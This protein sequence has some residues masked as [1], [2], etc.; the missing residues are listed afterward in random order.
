M[1]IAMAAA[2][3]T[4]ALVIGADA[5]TAR[6]RDDAI[7]RAVSD[8]AATG[9][10]EAS[11]DKLWTDAKGGV[12]TAV[13]DAQ[14]AIAAG[15]RWLAL[16]RLAQAR[17]SF[18]ATRFTLT[19]PAER[20]D[21]AAF[22]R[23]WS[24]LGTTL[25]AAAPSPAPLDAVR[26]AI[27]RALAEV[28]TPQVQINYDAALEYGRNTQPEYGLYFVGVAD[29]QRQFTILARGLTSTR[30]EAGTAPALRS[31]A[32]EIAAVQRDLLSLY[33]PPASV[34]RH[35]EFIVA[36]SALKEARQYD[37]LR[38]RHAALL[39]LLQGLQRTAMLRRGAPSETDSIAKQI[40]SFRARLEDP[41]VDHSIGL[42]FVE[43]AEAGL[44]AGTPA[45]AIAAAAVAF[46][47]LPRYFE[48]VGSASAMPAAG[49]AAAPVATVTL[50]RWP[51]T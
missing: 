39:K 47:V 27:V 13:K 41:R 48:S 21:L 16:E 42:L 35:S 25:G 50:V 29:A 23:E 32:P 40:A 14:A 26:P 30:S 3:A 20:K 12:E 34:D 6:G 15:R 7:G 51:F 5:Q 11:S 2:V 19:H 10:A 22:E 17:Q 31:V 33:K 38:L 18:L 24:R 44:D 8:F 4:A 28:A 43:R 46:D 1:S 49:T 9:A 36:S 45:G 37:A